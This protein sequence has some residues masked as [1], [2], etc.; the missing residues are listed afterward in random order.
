MAEK[1]KVLILSSDF[2]GELK[3]VKIKDGSVHVDD[4]EFKIDKAKPFR[5]KFGKFKKSDT[6]YLLKWN[7]ILPLQFKPME[8]DDNGY[9]E[10]TLIPIEL[11]E[12][13]TQITPDL[14]EETVSLRF[15]KQMKKYAE[16]KKGIGGENL[17][18]ML[19]VV[20]GL[21]LGIVILMWIIPMFVK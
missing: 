3:S 6:T 5:I 10:K 18:F 12:Y 21:I 14:L 13:K 16:G 8:I 1:C 17:G 11:E 15:L 20:F 7:T 19:R 9:R 4:K 2:T